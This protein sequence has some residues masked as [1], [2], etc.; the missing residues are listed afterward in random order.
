MNLVRFPRRAASFV[1]ESRQSIQQ[2]LE[3]VRIVQVGGCQAY[4]QGYS[5]TIYREMM[6]ASGLSSIDRTAAGSFAP[7]LACI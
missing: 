1:S 5:V 3:F 4:R 6:F 2:I 7:F